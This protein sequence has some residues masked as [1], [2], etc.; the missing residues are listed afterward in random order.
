[1]LT[2]APVPPSSQHAGWAEPREYVAF[3]WPPEEPALQAGWLAETELLI[4]DLRWLLRRP[5]H[6]Y[7]TAGLSGGVCLTTE[8]HGRHWRLGSECMCHTYVLV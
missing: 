5:Y 8:T 4:G 3:S 1:M 2:P 7:C 6:R